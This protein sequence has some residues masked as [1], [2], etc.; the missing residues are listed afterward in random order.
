MRRLQGC[1]PRTADCAILQ[2]LLQVASGELGHSRDQHAIYP[3]TMKL[4]ADKY[5][6]NLG[7]VRIPPLLR[8][9]FIYK[10]I[11]LV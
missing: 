7:Q 10:I 3:L 11:G 6:S 5:V 8:H 4:W 1:H 9:G 2:E